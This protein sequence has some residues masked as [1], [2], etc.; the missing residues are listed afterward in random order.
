MQDEGG[1]PH[2]QCCA[3]FAWISTGGAGTEQFPAKEEP[4]RGKKKDILARKNKQKL[5]YFLLLVADSLE[6]NP[7][8]QELT[9]VWLS[10]PQG[11]R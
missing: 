5:G 3:E 9:F 6:A 7:C 10:Q 4:R 8:K 1:K 2:A 11:D